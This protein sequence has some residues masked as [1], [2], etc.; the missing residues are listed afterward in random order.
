M[1]CE[2]I[3]LSTSFVLPETIWYTERRLL[4]SGLSAL[5]NSRLLEQQEAETFN[6]RYLKLKATMVIRTKK[7]KKL[8]HCKEMFT[9][10]PCKWVCLAPFYFVCNQLYNIQKEGMRNGF[11]NRRESHKTN[12]KNA[13]LK[14]LQTYSEFILLTSFESRRLIRDWSEGADLDIY[15]IT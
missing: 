15:K 12:M 9:D 5:S 4:H 11:S 3:F 7:K 1:T 8:V 2:S 6:I 10:I 13:I 14:D